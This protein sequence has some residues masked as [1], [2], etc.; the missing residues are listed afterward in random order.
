MS[1]QATRYN[2]H[3]RPIEFKIGDRVLKIGTKLS[4]KA[5]SKAGQI[6]DGY[7]GP[8]II[9]RE[10]SLTIYELKNLKGKSVGESNI[11]DHKLES[12]S[13]NGDI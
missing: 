12:I 1:K 13:S 2:L 9:K 3:R 4:N 10:I 5:D 7:E 6:Y 8:H 11:N